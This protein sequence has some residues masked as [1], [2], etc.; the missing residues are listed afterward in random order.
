M[1]GVLHDANGRLRIWLIG[2]AG[3]V[4]TGVAT[5]A[6]LLLV[7][8][9][10]RPAAAPPEE[11]F[12]SVLQYEQDGLRYTYHVLTGQEALFDSTADPKELR[13]L[14][15]ERGDDARRMRSAL[16]KELKVD[17]LDSLRDRRKEEIE[18]LKSLGYL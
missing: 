17:S 4:V 12:P 9:G 18:Q 11:D 13:N 16:E 2:L 14:L 1:R 10:N 7:S 6:I 3:L 8:S 15:N 5:A